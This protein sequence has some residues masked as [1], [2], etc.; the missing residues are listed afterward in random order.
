MNDGDQP[1]RMHIRLEQ[2]EDGFPPVAVETVWVQPRGEYF[3]VDSIPLFSDSIALNDLVAVDR[4]AEGH[5]WFREVETHSGHEVVRVLFDEHQLP[6]RDNV[7]GHLRDLGCRSEW[8]DQYWL[9]AVD[10][11][12]DAPEDGIRKFLD[13]GE[14]RDDWYWFDGF[15][16]EDG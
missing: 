8:S 7:R 1:E 15:R 11:P 3:L 5:S 10:I 14:N 9:L 4:D 12:P 16:L 13:E 6:H 2:D